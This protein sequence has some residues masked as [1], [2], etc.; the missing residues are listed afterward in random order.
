MATVGE[1]YSFSEEYIENFV[2]KVVDEDTSNPIEGVEVEIEYTG[3]GETSR[4]STTDSNGLT[5]F[6]L[7]DVASSATIT[8]NVGSL[9]E[10]YTH[11]DGNLELYEFETSVPFSEVKTIKI[12]DQCNENDL[13]LTWINTLGG[14]EQ[15]NFSARKSKGWD[16]IEKNVFNKDLFSSWDT[17]FISGSQDRKT[18]RNRWRPSITVRSQLLNEN[19]AT[20][21]SRIKLSNQ[22]FMVQGS[23]LIPVQV[24]TGSFQYFTDREKLPNIEFKITLPEEYS[25]GG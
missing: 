8:I 18:L 5:D 17:E 15:W 10:Q 16:N 1:L 7:V 6:V 21:I 2:V 22:V 3:Y 9:S 12:A 14:Y 25:Q 23:N 19:E 4:T 24:D 13:I 11:Q 20:T